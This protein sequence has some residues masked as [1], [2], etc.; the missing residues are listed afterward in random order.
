MMKIL[1][2]V[3]PNSLSMGDLSFFANHTNLFRL[4][5]SHGNLVWHAKAI[6]AIRK[7]CP[8][9]FILMDLPGVKPRTTNHEPIN[10]AYGD[11]VQFGGKTTD[12][13][14]KNVKL[15]RP[16]PKHTQDIK[17]FS[18]NDGQFPFD[19]IK[20]GGDYVRGKSRSQF[21]LL[22]KKGLN[23]PGSIYDEEAQLKVYKDFC[24]EIEDFD[25][26]GIGLSFVQTGGLVKEM[27]RHRPDLIIVSKVEN[28]EGLRNISDIVENSDVIMV[29][30]GDLA[31]EIGLNHLY[32][33]VETI[34]FETKSSGKPLVMATEN[35][36]SMTS[37]KTPSKS[38][39]MS[40]GHSASIGAD[41]IM[42]SEE[43]AVS[44][45]SKLI[46]TWLK[47][48][49]ENIG[50]INLK[51]DLRKNESRYNI[52]WNSLDQFKSVPKIIVS[53][54][55]HAI[56]DLLSV[57]PSGRFHLVTGKKKTKNLIKLFSND[58]KIIEHS[59]SDSNPLDIIWRVI[60]ENK[61]ELFKFSNQIIAI[62][63]SKYV[64]S[65]RA[66][67]ISVFDKIDF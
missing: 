61:L 58:I 6:K 54:S 66:N 16:I 43:T 17:Y 15:T 37:R 67:S 51:L 64:N 14:L 59:F 28:S 24:S 9:A 36:E 35:L 7:S 20:F 50:S 1:A 11:I 19:V 45:N 31:A 39:V 56:N 5:G 25:I 53:K 40:L 13:S 18:V 55:G 29:D 4:N 52:I 46:I 32:S 63:V 22:P 47:E 38:E 12:Q 26:D 41:C 30:R 10:I 27:R 21:T 60:D 65:P 42:L 48:F 57:D 34:A 44:D 2:T 62:Y 8:N 3:G 49:I 33:A 23:I